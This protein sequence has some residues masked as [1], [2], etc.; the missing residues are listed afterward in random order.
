MAVDSLFVPLF[1]AVMVEPEITSLFGLVTVPVM[2]PVVFDWA[3]IPNA[4]KATSK[5]E[6][7]KSRK[8]LD[9]AGELLRD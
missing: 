7:K 3:M 4:Q 9:I 6:T 1:F 2:A 5:R 8:N